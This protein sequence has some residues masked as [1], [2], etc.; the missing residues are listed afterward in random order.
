MPRARANGIEIEYESHGS[1]DRPA[2]ALI[3]GLGTQLIDWAPEL[4]QGLVRSGLRVIAFD[5]RDA[6]LSSK[7][8]SEYG[9]DAMADDVAGLLDQLG[10]ERAHL[11]GISLGGMVAQCFAYRHPER[12]RALF[13]VM[14]TSGSPDLPPPEEKVL[15]R[16]LE[17]PKGRDAVIRFQAETRGLVG[18]P[19]YPESEQQRLAAAARAYDRCY[20]PEGVARQSSAAQR[21]PERPAKAAAIRAPT[22]VIHGKADP[23]IPP[24]HGRELAQRI[25]DAEL[26][27]IEGMGHNIPSALAG[28]IVSAVSEFISKRGA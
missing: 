27:L 13:A 14:T 12:T 3:R 15:K 2:I 28:T 26:L 18:S 16:L 21:D 7:L 4:I 25:E 19:G 17:V 20:C 11:F 23:L 24:E 8:S 9:L 1:D 10:I 6:G 5:N 22:L